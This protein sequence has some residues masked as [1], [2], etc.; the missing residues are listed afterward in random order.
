M[1]DIQTARH[2]AAITR[3]A[4]GRAYEADAGTSGKIAVWFMTVLTTLHAGG[5]LAALQY[6]EKLAMP[7]PTQCALL[8]GLIATM[9]GAIAALVHYNSLADRWRQEMHY[10]IEGAKELSDAASAFA[11]TATKADWAASGLSIVSIGALALA[12]IFAI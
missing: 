12:G 2:L 9:L 1:T 3:E 11:E 8:S 10:E 7:Y 4:A 5:L 6:P